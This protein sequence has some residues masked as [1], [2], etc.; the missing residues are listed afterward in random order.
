[1]SDK[2]IWTQS[3]L[4]V[5][6]GSDDVIRVL[7]ILRVKWATGDF[8]EEC[9]S[10]LDTKLMFLTEEEKDFTAKLFDEDEW[11][12][13]LTE[14]QAVTGDIPKGHVT[15]KNKST[16]TVCDEREFVRTYVSRRLLA[17]SEG[18]IAALTA[19]MRQV[20]WDRKEELSPWPSPTSPFF[21]KWATGSLNALFRESKLTKKSA[22]EWSN[23]TRSEILQ[24]AFFH[25][26]AA[27]AGW[28]HRALSYVEQDGVKPMRKHR[29][30]EQG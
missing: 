24:A 3:C 14:A 18:E 28:K 2:S 17:L 26:H 13:S 25:E 9:R 22:S 12:R 8:P 1:M 19:T 16:P 20:E 7:D 30:A 27:V 10:L 11:I 15:K 29:G 23:G 5:V 21:D 6:Q 4:S